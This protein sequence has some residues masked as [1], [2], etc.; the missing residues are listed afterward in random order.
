[1]VQTEKYE[2]VFVDL[3]SSYKLLSFF[4]FGGDDDS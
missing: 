1:M 3:Y 2:L 4:S